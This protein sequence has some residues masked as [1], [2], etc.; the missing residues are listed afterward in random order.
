MLQPITD[1]L[2]RVLEIF[3]SLTGSYG[4]AIILLTV[5]VKVALHPLSRKYLR[6]MKHMQALAPQIAV[7]RERYKS[8]PKSMNVEVMNLYRANGVNPLSG[9]LPSVV[10]LPVL[11]ALL[12]IFRREG[13]FKGASFLGLPLDKIPTL[14]IMLQNPVLLV[15]PLVVGLSTYWQQ[16]MTITDPQQ[17]KMFIFMPIMVAWW[18]TIFPVALSLYWAVST[19]ASIAEY[20]LVVGRPQPVPTAGPRGGTRVGVLPQRPKGTKKK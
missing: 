1:F 15:V 20:Y 10:Q 3:R 11:F 17:A 9:C 4:T 19:F 13:I 14:Q 2:A 5:G 7:L 8:D 18:A 6:A 16:R 12:A